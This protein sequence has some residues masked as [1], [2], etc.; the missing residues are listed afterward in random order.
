M[1]AKLRI[2][3]ASK[4][5]SSSRK[6]RRLE[7]QL[8][9]LAEE[10]HMRR[11]SRCHVDGIRAQGAH[12][13]RLRGGTRRADD[14]RHNSTLATWSLI[15]PPRGAVPTKNVAPNSW[16]A[17]PEPKPRSLPD[18]EQLSPRLE[19]ELGTE[20]QILNRPTA[21]VAGRAET[22]F[23]IGNERRRQPPTSATIRA[24]AGAAAVSS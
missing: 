15:A 4:F 3:L 9:A 18:E 13:T 11:R 7:V 19:A 22:N 12:T 17:P 24:A 21:D 10:F 6:P 5:A 20:P 1:R 8:I 16:H 2:V 14:S 23:S